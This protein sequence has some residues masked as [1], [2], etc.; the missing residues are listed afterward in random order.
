MA[1]LGLASSQPGLAASDAWEYEANLYL[2][3][4]GMK[5]DAL[6]GHVHRPERALEPGSR[7]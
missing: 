3:A 2:H 5:G 1:V 4:V 7:S 6:H